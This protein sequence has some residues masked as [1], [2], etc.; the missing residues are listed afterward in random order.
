ML[1]KTTREPSERW[2]LLDAPNS[3]LPRLHGS[4]GWISFIIGMHAIART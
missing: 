1:P 4:A 3:L 2:L